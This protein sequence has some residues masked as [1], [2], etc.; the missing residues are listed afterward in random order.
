LEHGETF[1][2]FWLN[3]ASRPK[4]MMGRKQMPFRMRHEAKH[5]SAFIAQSSQVKG[6]AIGIGWKRQS[7]VAG[8]TI[9]FAIAERD[10]LLQ[11]KAFGGGRV[12][13]DESSFSMGDRQ[14]DLV[15][16]VEEGAR[17][18]ADL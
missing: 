16:P 3:F 12:A 11:F 2:V 9:G 15:D 1:A 17:V 10:L 4:R 5:S 14:K 8:R 18:M 6:C 7:V 13:N